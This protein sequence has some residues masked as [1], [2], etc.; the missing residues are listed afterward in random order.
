MKMSFV[1][2]AAVLVV[3]SR[4]AHA[5]TYNAA[6]DFSLAANPNGVWSYMSGAPGAAPSLLKNKGTGPL[7]PGAGAVSFWNT[8]ARSWDAYYGIFANLGTAPV[9]V[10]QGLVLPPGTLVLHPANKAGTPA[11]LRF[12][13][14]AAGEYAVD[15]TFT[16]LDAQAKKTDIA[17]KING[18]EALRKGLQGSNAKESFQKTV[19]LEAGQAV[20]FV[21]GNG[22]DGFGDDAVQL[23]AT[24]TRVEQPR[25]PV[26]FKG[27]Y[28]L[29][30]VFQGANK[31]LEGNE[32]GSPVKQGAAFMDDCKNVSGQ[33][34]QLV[35][36]GEFYRL[37]TQFQGDQKCLEGNQAASTVKGGAAF[38]DTCQN[39]S[40]QLWRVIPEGPNFRLKTQFQGDQKCLEGN[41]AASTVKG[42]AAFM[43]TCQNVSGQLWQLVAQ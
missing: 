40:G 38:M 34:W 3:A 17:L 23:A 32:A 39:V 20:D 1:L 31:C 9:T 27:W 36:E 26:P 22:G 33:L 21:V 25:P 28:R 35:P 19:K 5:Q 41:Q 24:I 37:K 30:T 15:A 8:G 2:A 4:S 10:S 14:P 18:A 43:D 11:V 7:E 29:K 6:K 12:L 42:G 13:A 16:T